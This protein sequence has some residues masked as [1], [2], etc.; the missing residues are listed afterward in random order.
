MTIK[1]KTLRG[2]HLQPPAA[3]PFERLDEKIQIVDTYDDFCRFVCFAQAGGCIETWKVREAD[4]EIAKFYGFEIGKV[5]TKEEF[6]KKI[7]EITEEKVWEC[8]KIYHE[9]LGDY[10]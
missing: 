4:R 5:Y 2:H 7:R 10:L 3:I 9:Y 8:W 1:I 6:I